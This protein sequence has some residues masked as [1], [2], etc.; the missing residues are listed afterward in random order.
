MGNYTGQDFA[1]LLMGEVSGNWI[2]IVGR[3]NNGPLP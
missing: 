2:N 1:A 3:A